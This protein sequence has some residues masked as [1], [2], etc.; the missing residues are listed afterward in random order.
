ML[1]NANKFLQHD[2][3]LVLKYH[4]TQLIQD[5]MLK[6]VSPC[7]ESQSYQEGTLASVN[8]VNPAVQVSVEK[9]FIG[10]STQQKINNLLD[11]GDL[12]L[13][14]YQPFSK[15]AQNFMVTVGRLLSHYLNMPNGLIS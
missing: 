3:S 5:V 6:F 2:E 13:H 4:L 14:Q 11:D 1:T 8:F 9:L 12:S 15:A 10:H 7:Q